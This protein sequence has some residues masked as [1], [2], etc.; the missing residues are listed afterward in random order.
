MEAGVA[1]H[2]W[3]IEEI[4]SLIPEPVVKKRGPYKKRNRDSENSK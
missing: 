1:D 3:S 2:V 4:A